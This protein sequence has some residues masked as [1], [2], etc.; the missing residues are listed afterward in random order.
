MRFFAFVFFS[1]Y[2]EERREGEVEAEENSQWS[3]MEVS[4]QWKRY[5]YSYL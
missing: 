5:G 1:Y 3:G 2:W 4:L